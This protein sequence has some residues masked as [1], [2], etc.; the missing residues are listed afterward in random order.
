MDVDTGMASE[1]DS[2]EAGEAET[3]PDA[4][5]APTECPFC[6]ALT[7]SLKRYRWMRWVLYV[8]ITFRVRSGIYVACPKCMRNMVLKDTFSPLNILAANLMWIVVVLPY[9]LVLM[10][11]S[12]VPGHSACV[13]RR[14]RGEE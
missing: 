8:G 14:L 5:T 6:H 13:K 7:T 3:Q 9:C 10:V 11:L 2:G 4:D 12:T 1:E